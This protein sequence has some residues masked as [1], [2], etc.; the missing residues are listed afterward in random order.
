MCV[1]S[2]IEPLSK[3]AYVVMVGRRTPTPL[4]SQIRFGS[5]E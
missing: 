3:N 5:V 1:R 4:D 2:Q